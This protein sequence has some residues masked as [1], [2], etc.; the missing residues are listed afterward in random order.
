MEQR[1]V[2]VAING[3]GRIGRQAFKA[4]M[5]VGTD[6]RMTLSPRIDPSQIELV[7]VNDLVDVRVLAHLLRYDT[8]YGRYNKEM[9][10]EHNGEVIEWEGHTSGDDHVTEIGD[11]KNFLIIGGHRIRFFTE[12]DPTKLP[13]GEMG[14][15]VVIESTGVFTSYESAKVH[16]QAGAKRVVISAPAKGEE[17]QEGQTLVFGTELTSELIDKHDVVSNASC[18][19]NCISPVVQVLHSRI[20]IEKAMMTT[21]HA[22]TAT[23]ALVDAPIPKDIRRGRA[24][25]GNIIPSSTGAAVA[26]TYVIPDLQGHFDGIA[27]RVPV[28]VGSLSDITAVVKKETTVEEVNELFIEMS[29]HPLY[30]DILI[31]TREPLV[32]SDIIGNPASAI[33]DLEFTRVVGGNLVKI[34]AWYDNEWGYSNRL[35]EM[36]VEVGR[37]G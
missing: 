26:T 34:L 32:S 10:V 27:I 31:A 12:R 4:C 28:I 18:T 2:K 29:R 15:D 9:M 20:G 13:W 23:Q 1:K 3:F 30:K 19:T 11:G 24:A 36:A 16:L 37:Q 14:V 25:A 21:V 17:G 8:V 22:Y 7:A 33:V 35:V 5:G 6:M